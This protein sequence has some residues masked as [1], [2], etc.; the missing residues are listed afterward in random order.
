MIIVFDIIGIFT[1]YLMKHNINRELGEGMKKSILFSR[2]Q[3][4][5]VI[6]KLYKKAT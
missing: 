6:S 3:K 2:V 4:D 1:F 5:K